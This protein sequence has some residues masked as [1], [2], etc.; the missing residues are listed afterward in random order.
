[1]S[2]PRATRALAVAVLLIAA[3]A[4]G[5]PAGAQTPAPDPLD[6]ARALVRAGKL[7]EAA[8][9]YTAVLEARPQAL[10]ARTERGRVLGWL[11]RY[12]EALADFDRVLAVTPRDVDARVGKGRVLAYARRYAE[13]EAELRGALALDP[14][15]ADAQLA[16]GDV[17]A[18]QQRYPEAARAFER[19]RELAP[20]S[21][22]PWVGLAKLRFWQDDLEGARAAYEAALRLEPG[23]AE[24]T[25]GLARLAAIPPPRR[26]RLDAGV[27]YEALSRGFS[28]WTQE[29]TRLTGQ[30]ARK[31]R[32]FL[33]VDQYR[34][35][36]RDDTQ[37]TV[38]GVQGLPGELTLS[39]AFSYGFDA[40][41]VARQVYEVE[42]GKRLAPWATGFL[43]YRHSS[44]P[45]DVQADIVTP[46][47]EVAWGP[48]LAV[49]ARYYYAHASAS[50]DGSAGLLRLTANPD[51]R[52]STYVVGAYGQET[53]LAGTV[54]EVARAATVVTV[55]G[56]VVWRVAD[57]VGVRLDYAYEDRH[58]S[59]TKH[60]IGA[61]VFVEF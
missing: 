57:R 19:A 8:A 1:M 12:D 54:V 42:A 28:D 29:W 55:G 61:A 46:A 26:F 37:L 51:G 30:V 7:E 47:L 48:W 33:G 4:L 14:A 36:D 41:V 40:Q 49:L 9:A 53:F 52:L 32:L 16:L 60:G 18:W 50:G 17:L 38:G 3:A 39:G 34:R 56:G 5:A 13:A 11:G 44:Y 59:Y 31:T 58:G 24:A 21:P 15:A 35:F 23:N 43:A 27:R 2:R 10:E 25:E 22:E 6:A 20:A 45:G